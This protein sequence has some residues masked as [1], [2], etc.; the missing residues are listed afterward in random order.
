MPEPTRVCLSA[1][2]RHCLIELL[3]ERGGLP[4]DPKDKCKPIT[5]HMRALRWQAERSAEVVKWDDFVAA[6]VING[7]ESF[8]KTMMMMRLETEQYDGEAGDLLYDF[9]VWIQSY[10]DPFEDVRR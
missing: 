10:K 3:P 1:T 5:Q 7:F 8:H 4:Q 9:D 2:E 6:S